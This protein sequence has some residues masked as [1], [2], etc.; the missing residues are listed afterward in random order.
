[1]K[2]W[3]KSLF[4]DQDKNGSL[5]I[6][7]FREYFKF[8]HAGSFICKAENPAGSI[9][10]IPIQLKPRNFFFFLY[11]M[12]IRFPLEIYD[13][14][15]IEVKSPYG[16]IQSSVIISCEISP[17]IASSYV[18]IIGWLEKI[19]NQIIELDLRKHFFSKDKLRFDIAYRTQNQ[20]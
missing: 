8:I 11:L 16:F 18:N 14:Y 19:D 10:S 20:V 15:E 6:R 4:S 7:P 3:L 17:P 9:Q 5:F 12:I 1:M 2:F 13:A